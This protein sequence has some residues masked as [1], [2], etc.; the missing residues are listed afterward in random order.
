MAPTHTHTQSETTPGTTHSPAQRVNGALGT[1]S[2]CELCKAQLGTQLC[3]THLCEYV[4]PYLAGWFDLG[5]NLLPAQPPKSCH[6]GRL[7]K[8]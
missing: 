8:G 5:V 1:A 3:P 2:D 6:A 7:E 4:P